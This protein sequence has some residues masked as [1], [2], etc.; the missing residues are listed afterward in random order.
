MKD[1]KAKRVAYIGMLVGLALVLSYVEAMVPLPVGIPGIKVGLANLVVMV[2]LYTLD[3][4]KAVEI[5]VLRI[6]LVGFS[7]GSFS[8]MIYSLAGGIAS[9][10]IMIIAKRLDWFS[11][12]GVSI[13][14]GVFHNLGQIIVAMVVVENTKLIFYLPVLIISGTI[15]GIGI[16]IMSFLITKRVVKVYK[17]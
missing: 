8:S 5:S 15:A 13:L 10:F 3:E 11:I 6:V 16:G 12:K 7:F 9:L 2:A 17:E 4:R 14:G 1:N